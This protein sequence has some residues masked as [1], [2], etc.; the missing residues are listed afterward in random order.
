M[1]DSERDSSRQPVPDVTP[2]DVTRVIRRDF[3]ESQFDAALAVVREYSGMQ[4]SERGRARVQLAALKLAK[5]DLDSLRVQIGV[6]RQ[7]YRDALATAEY[8]EYSGRGFQV[9][10]LPVADQQRIIANDWKQ[11]EE[12]LRT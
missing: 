12:W 4:G 2:E 8:P 9:R 7:D 3:A 5:G 1:P 6:A 10:D 11:Y